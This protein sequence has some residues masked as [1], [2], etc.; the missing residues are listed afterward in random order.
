MTKKE[1]KAL[2]A[3]GRI[4]EVIDE[5][6]AESQG[7]HLHNEIVHQSDRWREYEKTDRS[8]ENTAESQQILR[9]RISMAVLSLIDEVYASSGTIARKRLGTWGYISR[10][11][12]LVAIIAGI[13]ASLKHLGII[14]G[15]KAVATR[16]ITVLV[17][18]PDGKDDIILPNRGTVY[19]LYGDAKIPEQINNE[20]EATF[21]QIDRR[22]FADDAFVE[23]QFEDPEG[24][25]YRLRYPDSTYHLEQGQYIALEAVLEGMDQLEGTVKDFVTGE[26]LD[27]VHIRI[28]GI[29]Y[30]TNVFG[31]FTL[32]IPKGRQAQFIDLRLEKA[33]YEA[34]ELQNVPTTTD[35]EQKISLKPIQ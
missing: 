31:E 9:N 33:G 17:H 30:Y 21:K 8:A 3:Q 29:S 19:L 12:L 26:P 35:Q 27:S 11:A 7:G 24:E 2:H 10:A 6:L 34:K 16:S 20:G 25:P 15:T 5:L 28:R 1:L 18:G 22:F 13:I 23:F 14:G 4:R 32:D